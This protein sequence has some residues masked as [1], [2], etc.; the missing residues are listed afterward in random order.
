MIIQKAF[1]DIFH[2]NKV[3]IFFTGHVHLYE[4][5]YPT[6]R[7][8]PTS[9]SYDHPKATVHIISGAAGVSSLL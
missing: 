1:E 4:R 3:N 8:N 7:N 2:E 9:T 6:Y 5:Q